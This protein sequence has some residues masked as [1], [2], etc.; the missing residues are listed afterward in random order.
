MTG[1]PLHCGVG[2]WASGRRVQEMPDSHYTQGSAG[3]KCVN[4]RLK[5]KQTVNLPGGIG[6]PAG[7]NRCHG[8]R[9]PRT[10]R[11]L[12]ERGRGEGDLKNNMIS[13]IQAGAFHGLSALR[14]LDLSN[15]RIGCLNPEIF[16][17]LTSLTRL[18]LSGNIFSTLN[19]DLLDGL[20]S[21]KVIDFNT[22]LLVCDCNLL[23][24]LTWERSRSVRISEDTVCAYPSAL[25]GT[26]FRELQ[27]SQLVCDGPLEL[28]FLQLIPVM[29]QVV[30]QGD[31]L[32]LPLHRPYLDNS[33]R[34]FELILSNIYLLASGEWECVIATARGNA[35]LKVDIVVI[36]TSATYC[37]A[38]RVA[39]NRGEFRSVR[40]LA[41]TQ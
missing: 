1:S 21:L 20:S 10:G 5:A 16:Q 41:W 36:D 18:N 22:E 26:P 2:R 35:S 11:W 3:V 34:V 28:P 15:N 27:E 25:R 23:W 17:S 37:P 40:P 29:R 9:W 31:R 38:Q 30:F 14:R 6:Q 33:T 8:D 12:Q 4:D 19:P 13:T 24:A 39:N 32:S 7:V